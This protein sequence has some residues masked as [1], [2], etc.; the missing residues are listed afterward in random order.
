MLGILDGFAE[1]EPNWQINVQSNAPAAAFHALDQRYPA[2]THHI[3]HHFRGHYAAILVLNQPWAVETIADL[4]RHALLIGF[5][6]LDTIGWDVIYPAPE[7]LERGFRFASRHAD[8]LTYISAFSRD[9]FRKRFRVADDVSEDVVRLSLVPDE[10][11][12]PELMD[13]PTAEHVLLFGN[14]Y[15]HKGVDPAIR[16]L[17]SAFP[18]QKFVVVGA[19]SAPA[20][21]VRAVPSGPA[22]AR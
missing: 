13:Q 21:N 22:T 20:S 5:T 17:A 1:L 16:L 10:Q 8:I 4:H 18:L 14:S 12:L 2:F 6:I 19:K 3:G 9:R 7:G 15:D 11:A